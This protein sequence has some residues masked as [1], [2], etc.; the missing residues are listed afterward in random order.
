MNNS[1]VLFYIHA[2]NNP[3]ALTNQKFKFVEVEE[4]SS[5]PGITCRRGHFNGPLIVSYKK[6]SKGGNIYE[7]FSR[8]EEYS[9]VVDDLSKKAKSVF[10]N[11][12]ATI[13]DDRSLNALLPAELWD[14]D[15]TG[16]EFIDSKA[17]ELYFND[18]ER[19]R[20][21]FQSR[22]ELKFAMDSY[23]RAHRNSNKD[24]YQDM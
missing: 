20:Y 21:Q 16:K 11:V 2:S 12:V 18:S 6:N 1:F 3:E 24:L 13:S 9:K 22:K 5:L 10:E 4:G 15:I 23:E 14:E 19:Q 8:V 7:Y 17:Y